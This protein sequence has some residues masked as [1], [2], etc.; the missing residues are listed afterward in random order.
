VSPVPAG[1]DSSAATDASWDIRRHFTLAGKGNLRSNPRPQALY[2]QY[3]MLSQVIWS[4]RF[5]AGRQA[6]KRRVTLVLIPQQV[7]RYGTISRIW[8]HCWLPSPAH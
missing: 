7:T 3:Y 8:L 2:R 6:G 1:N 5:H 4:N